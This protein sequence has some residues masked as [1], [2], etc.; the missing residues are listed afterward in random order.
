MYKHNKLC[1]NIPFNGEINAK[2]I[3]TNPARMCRTSS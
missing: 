1:Y 2:R 3:N